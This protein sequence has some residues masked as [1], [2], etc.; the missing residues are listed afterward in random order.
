LRSGRSLLE[1]HHGNIVQH[2]QRQHNEDNL[3]FLSE[4]EDKSRPI[5]YEIIRTE[6]GL[7]NRV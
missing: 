7:A 5:R 3:L 2:L 6:L 1:H 4:L